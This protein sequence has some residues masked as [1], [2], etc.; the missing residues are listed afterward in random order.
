[1]FFPVLFFVSTILF[2]F[3]SIFLTH[4]HHFGSEFDNVGELLGGEARNNH[5]AAKNYKHDFSYDRERWNANPP[6]IVVLAGPHKAASTN[7]Q[8]VLAITL[9]TTLSVENIHQNQNPPKRF[10][11]PAHPALSDWAWPL[12]LRKETTGDS[13]LSGG[14]KRSSNAKFFAPLAAL[15]SGQSRATWWTAWNSLS[16]GNA[17]GRA[18]L[19][20]QV[21]SYYKGLFRQAHQTMGKKVVIGAEAL[22]A[23]VLP[24]HTGSL[25][26]EGEE[27]HVATDSAEKIQTLLDLFPWSNNNNATAPLKLEE[28]EVHINYR[29]P[30]T[31]HLVSLWHEIGGS[32]GNITLREF[33]AVHSQTFYATNSLAVALQFVRLGIHTTIIHM[34]GYFER[35]NNAADSKRNTDSETATNDVVVGGLGGVVACE[36]LHLGRSQGLCDDRNRLVLPS[37]APNNDLA[38]TLAEAVRS[39]SKADPA[40]RNMTSEGLAAV[41]RAYSNYDCGVWRHLQKYQSGGTLRILYPSRDL[42]AGCDPNGKDSVSFRALAQELASIAKREAAYD[43]KAKK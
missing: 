13:A 9:G 40:S 3:V 17:T 39:N 10:Q 5:D 24:L 30:R 33:L 6:R 12:G 8:D 22:D 38:D 7:I 2:S 21:S 35:Q 29:T 23:L 27:L 43:P 19:E 25:G 34:Q 20:N 42:F 14:F 11:Q 18:S 15:I 26:D 4:Q 28:L 32:L 31:G 37:N 1:M 16:E 36:V 41:E